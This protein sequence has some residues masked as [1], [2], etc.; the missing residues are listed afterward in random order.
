[1]EAFPDAV[2]EAA[3]M[4]R[5]YDDVNDLYTDEHRVMA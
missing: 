2:E 4:Q 3:L 1:M 5:L